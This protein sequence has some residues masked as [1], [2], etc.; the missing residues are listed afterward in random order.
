MTGDN[1]SRKPRRLFLPLAFLA[2]IFVL[3]VGTFGLH[4]REY[5]GEVSYVRANYQVPVWD[6]AE[7]L[8][9]RW[10][11]DAADNMLYREDLVELDGLV[12]RLAGKNFVRDTDYSYSVV[13]DNHG[14][15][16][17]ITFALEPKPIVKD[18]AA[19]QALGVPIMYIQPTTKF[20]EG[21]TEFPPTLHDK[22]AENVA[23]NFALLEA[24]GVPVLDLRAAAEADGLDKE[25]MFYRTDHH[26]RAETAFWAVGETVTAVADTF[27][28]QLDPTGIYSDA[29]NWQTQDYPQSF[30][31]S[32][33]RRVGRLYGGLDDFTLIS[34]DFATEYTVEITQY[35]GKTTETLSGSFAETVLD[36]TKLTDPS[37]YTSRYNA[38]W[39]AD[40]PV[41]L[42]DN[43]QNEDGL[44]VLLIKDSYS[45]PYG[46]FLSTMTDKLYMVDLRYFDIA[47]LAQYI[48]DIRPDLMLIM[49]S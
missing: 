29:A 23:E 15:L 48:G 46:A 45:L 13:K 4:I 42:A 9:E 11:A 37:V 16:Q 6:R 43:L 7:A 36:M 39:G 2:V 1:R 19:Y 8:V 20:I 3:G 32:Q 14:W 28:L 33:G 47:D 12:Q 26:W 49:Y 35:D 5:V 40:Y 17:F 24:A 22:T 38:Y 44:T 10:T 30:L 41:V 31:G 27:G 18:I 34:P 25:Q 21:Y